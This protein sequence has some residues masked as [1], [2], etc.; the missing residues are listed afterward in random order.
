MA[1]M[2]AA[3]GFE[4]CVVCQKSYHSNELLYGARGMI[5]PACESDLRIEQNFRKGVWMTVFGGP[6]LAFSGTSF[7]CA[8]SLFGMVGPMLM[9]GFGIAAL[10]GGFRSL[11]VAISSLRQDADMELGG[12]EKGALF[13]SAAV[14]TLWGGGLFLF[15]GLSL[16]A[17]IVTLAS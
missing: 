2:T 1:T 12:L 3:A 14:S 11:M 4:P 10:L 6:I 16:L 9:F 8:M 13:A 5:C 7:G 15:G 17:W